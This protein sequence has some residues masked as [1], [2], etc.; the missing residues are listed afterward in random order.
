MSVHVEGIKR[1]GEEVR[2]TGGDYDDADDADEEEGEEGRKDGRNGNDTF[3]PPT[4]T[5]THTHT[6]LTGMLST[7]E[8]KLKRG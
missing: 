3:H 2:G 1:G 7:T 6:K 5:H 8:R 4:D